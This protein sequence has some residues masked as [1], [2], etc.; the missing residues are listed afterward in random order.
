[1]IRQNHYQEPIRTK[2]MIRRT[3]QVGQN[4]LQYPFQTDNTSSETN[5]TVNIS[6]GSEQLLLPSLSS[7]FAHS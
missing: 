2:K 1:M 5:Q 6:N 4:Y 3:E 7:N